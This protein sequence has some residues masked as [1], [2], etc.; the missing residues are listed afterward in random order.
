MSGLDD[1]D[2]ELLELAGDVQPGEEEEHTKSYDDLGNLHRG[3]SSPASGLTATK[4]VP[5]SSP[6]RDTSRHS[7]PRS[8]T[9]RRRKDDSEEEGEA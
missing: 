5:K 3:S 1:L 7:G 6:H 8:V 9:P 4:T 2:D